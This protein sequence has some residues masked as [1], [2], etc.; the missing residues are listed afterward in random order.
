MGSTIIYTSHYME[1]IEDLCDEIVI[2]DKGKVIAKGTKE[3][4]KALIATEDKVS[5]GVSNISYTIIDKIKKRTRC[6]GMCY[7]Q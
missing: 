7:R 5:I 2:M 1:E 3:E 6:K 4:L